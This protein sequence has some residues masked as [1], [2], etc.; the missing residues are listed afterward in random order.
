MGWWGVKG[1]GR[2]LFRSNVW[3]EWWIDLWLCS[4]CVIGSS[5]LSASQRSGCEPILRDQEQSH[6]C[7][8]WF[9]A[10]HSG[11]MW[12][13]GHQQSSKSTKGIWRERNPWSVWTCDSFWCLQR[14]DLLL[15]QYFWD[16]WVITGNASQPFVAIQSFSCIYVRLFVTPCLQHARLPCP[17][18]SPRVCSNSCSLSRWCHPSISSPVTPSPPSL[19]LSQHQGLFQWVYPSHQVAKVLELHLQHQSF[20]PWLQ[21]NEEH[22]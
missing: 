4:V 5:I 7:S 18:L 22:L 21:S 20:Q 17:S 12:P 11:N 13:L 10:H 8:F 15:W 6:W 3:A 19:D 9:E 2:Y 1:R 16:E 14:C